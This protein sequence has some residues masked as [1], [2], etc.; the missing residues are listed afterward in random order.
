MIFHKINLF[1][2]NIF[3]FITFVVFI[4]FSSCKTIDTNGKS[5]LSDHVYKSIAIISTPPPNDLKDTW[6]NIIKGI[7]KKL[8]DMPFLGRVIRSKD[9]EKKIIKNPKL[10]SKLRIYISTLSLTGISDKEISFEIKEELDVQYFLFLDFLSFPCTKGCSSDKQWLIRL[11]LID[12]KRGDVIFWVRKK[13]ELSEEKINSE[14]YKE[15]AIKLSTEVVNEF[16][17]GF[18][19]PW[20]TLRYNNLNQNSNQIFNSSLKK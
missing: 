19:I 8:E 17:K 6:P 2:K 9:Q 14:S 13:F 4:L 12:P 7:E 3:L 11:K 15:L 5:D 16:S 20:Q 10:R 1:L 18:I